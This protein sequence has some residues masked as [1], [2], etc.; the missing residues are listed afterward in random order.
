MTIK[1]R[2][3][4]ADICGDG[5]RELM[6]DECKSLD[7]FGFYENG[8][9]N[10]DS[11]Y[12]YKEWIISYNENYR[13]EELYKDVFRQFGSTGLDAISGFDK[14]EVLVGAE[15]I[16]T[17]SACFFIR[18]SSFDIKLEEIINCFQLTE[19]ILYILPGFGR[20]EILRNKI[21]GFKISIPSGEGNHHNTPHVHVEGPDKRSCTLDIFDF[22]PLQK[23]YTLKEHEVS[24]VRKQLIPYRTY[25]ANYWNLKCDGISVEM[26]L[27]RGENP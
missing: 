2:C 3:I 18:F 20:G 11:P 22:K 24:N 12:S 19:M 23:N 17:L 25:I 27:S 21:D 8:V 6:E 10:Y 4:F 7:Q 1:V 13:V 9:E 5:Y 14:N 26:Y 16:L 15:I